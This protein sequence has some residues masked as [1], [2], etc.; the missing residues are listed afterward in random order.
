MVSR[1]YITASAAD[2][3]EFLSVSAMSL[4]QHG[5]EEQIYHSS[6]RGTLLRL[7]KHRLVLTAAW[8]KL[9]RPWQLLRKRAC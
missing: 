8:T 4:S 3:V 2:I 1:K 7:E 6:L 9:V 5:L